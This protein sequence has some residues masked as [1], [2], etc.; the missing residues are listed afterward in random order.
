M[1]LERLIMAKVYIATAAFR[2]LCV[3]TVK[4]EK[5]K[6]G[7]RAAAFRRLCVETVFGQFVYSSFTQPPSGGCVLKH[8]IQDSHPN[9]TKQPP[10]GGCVLKRSNTVCQLPIFAAA[11]RRLCVETGLPCISRRGRVQPPSGGCV[12][13]QKPRQIF[14]TLP[15][16]AAFRRLCVETNT[17]SGNK[18]S[19]FSNQP[20]SGGCVLKQTTLTKA[21]G[22]INSRL[23]AAVC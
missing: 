23:R 14:Q 12:L 10:S 15:K 18:C 7:F 21:T 4:A 1:K 13:K 9:P 6:A 16:P 3:E 8:K 19:T 20:P 2:R 17:V 11:F 5:I 22:D